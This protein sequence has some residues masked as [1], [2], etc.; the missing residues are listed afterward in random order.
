MQFLTK[1][2]PKL[3][4][5]YLLKENLRLTLK[6]GSDDI[7]DALTKWIACAHRCR[8]PVLRDLLKKITRHF[9]A[10]VAA[11][12]FWLSNA[13]FEA[14][15]NKILIIRSAFGFCN[16]DNLAVVVMLSCPAFRATLPGR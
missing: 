10:I 12:K 14:T 3:Y 8:I 11:S 2:N 9:D 13:R 1:V 4:R 15:N 7:S 6:A 16:V 5:A